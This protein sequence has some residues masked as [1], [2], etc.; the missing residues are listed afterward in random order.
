MGACTLFWCNGFSNS[1]ILYTV[2]AVIWLYESVYRQAQATLPMLVVN[3]ISHLCKFSLY[4]LKDCN[5]NFLFDVF[6][7]LFCLGI[8]E[9]M[10]LVWAKETQILA[11]LLSRGSI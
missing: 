2:L 6:H 11:I 1:N 5:F 8:A 7:D 3:K 9:K 4:G 10:I